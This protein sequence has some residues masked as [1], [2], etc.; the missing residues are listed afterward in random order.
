MNK[1]GKVSTART[2]TL[3]R[4]TKETE[5]SVALNLDGTGQAKIASGVGFL[6]TC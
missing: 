5:I 3:T 6:I 4:A 1:D 2:A